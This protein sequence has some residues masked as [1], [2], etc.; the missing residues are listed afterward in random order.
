MTRILISLLSKYLQP[1]FLFIKEMEGEYDKLVFIS[2]SEMENPP[3]E[4]T[5]YLLQAL[6]LPD[7][8]VKPI[9]VHADDYSDIISKLQ[10]Q[11]F[12]H[13]DQY[14]INPTG[15]TKVMAI[16]LCTFFRSFD[17]VR[18][19]YIPEGKNIISNLYTNKEESRPLKYR[20]TLKEYFTLNRMSFQCEPLMHNKIMA[21][22]VF[23]KLKKARFNKY[24]V[25][26]LR[27][28]HS[29]NAGANKTYYSGQW[30]EEYVYFRLKEQLKLDDE[31]ICRGAK[32][33]KKGK[34]SHNNEIDIIF[35]KANELYIIEC[36]TSLA[37]NPKADV[38][39][40]WDS[41]MY[42]LAA[43][44]KDFGLRVHSYIF[45]LHQ[46]RTVS[47]GI[48]DAAQKRMGILGIKK[49]LFA[50]DFLKT[51]INLN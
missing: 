4:S 7:K 13:D 26:E 24:W 38:K 46:S 16:A 31:V 12:S 43:I 47:Q 45:T 36:K 49:T 21:D 48:I 14:I 33:F 6:G 50:E 30:F 5:S 3:A 25:M 18:Y 22:G 29:N 41:Y 37:K 34:D 9:L 20:L 44:A 35:I 10:K 2:T 39:D 42:K 40:N 19:C 11:E 15:G 51:K 23:E 17:N 28:P 32:I 1:N 27:D 8:S